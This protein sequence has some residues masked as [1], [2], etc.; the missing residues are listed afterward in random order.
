MAWGC[1]KTQIEKRRLLGQWRQMF[2]CKKRQIISLSLS[3]VFIDSDNKIYTY[4][5]NR[6]WRNFEGQRWTKDSLLQIV[7]ILSEWGSD[8][9]RTCLRTSHHGGHKRWQ[10][11]SGHCRNT[12][13]RTRITRLLEE[14]RCQLFLCVSFIFRTIP[15][16]EEFAISSFIFSKPV[17][18]C[19]FMF[20]SSVLLSN[21]GLSF[22]N[23]RWFYDDF[24][25][26]FFFIIVILWNLFPYYYKSFSWQINSFIFFLVSFGKIFIFL[27]R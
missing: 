25:L 9:W 18:F 12:L 1:T 27:L 3:F 14:K 23:S 7:G 6:I 17:F 11:W 22:P 16:H 20:S 5:F 4:I 15:F 8:A 10:M 21:L 26:L 2:P 13:Y 24:V 19:A